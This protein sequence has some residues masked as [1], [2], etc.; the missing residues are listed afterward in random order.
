MADSQD[1][2]SNK[3]IN[4]Y[5]S[6][7]GRAPQ[8]HMDWE[9]WRKVGQPGTYQAPPGSPSTF[10][11]VHGGGG[12]PNYNADTNHYNMFAD[13][14][15]T[16]ESTVGSVG[17]WAAKK[18][19]GSR[20]GKMDKDK[21]GSTASSRNGSDMADD[22]GSMSAPPV[23]G[24]GRSQNASITSPATS[25]GMRR[26]RR[27]DF[28]GA[29]ASHGITMVQG[30]D[31]YGTINGNMGGHNF[32]SGDYD[33][34][35]QSKNTG[36]NQ[37]AFSGNNNA[38][39]VNINSGGPF[40]GG[41]TPPQ[42]QS[43]PPPV[44]P[45]GPGAPPTPPIVTDT[46]WEGPKR[47]APTKMQPPGTGQP[48]AL[49]GKERPML[50]TGQG[51]STY[52]NT[53][54]VPG[55]QET[56]DIAR[57]S[58]ITELATGGATEGE[59][60][61]AGTALNNRGTQSNVNPATQRGAGDQTPPMLAGYENMKETAPQQ[62]TR[63]GDNG[64][65]IPASAPNG[66]GMPQQF[67]RMQGAVPAQY[68]TPSRTYDQSNTQ[69]RQ[70][71]PSPF[72]GT[73]ETGP[74]MPAQYGAMQG[75]LRANPQNYATRVATAKPTQNQIAWPAGSQPAANNAPEAPAK[76]AGGRKAA[77]PKASAKTTEGPK[78]VAA[79]KAAVPKATAKTKEKK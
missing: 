55:A 45:S 3:D 77:A 33:N 58:K 44:G 21:S 19:K 14:N 6:Q 7:Q 13:L 10:R 39:P 69:I 54:G 15:K 36:G 35:F 61:A 4:R 24:G 18:Y 49:P 11:G 78:S 31:N 22:D 71:N 42:G 1:F 50:P 2:N 56:K 70:N 74:G 32:G 67:G 20:D 63:F 41:P 51:P 29:L 72:H 28:S 47:P 46:D 17:M 62:N 68:Q 66:G 79:K 27:G 9:T 30:N 37:T 43:G 34:S 40:G 64:M 48:P 60:D 65:G 73:G 8:S 5:L 52:G 12:G 75:A 26:G 23:A 25:R 57:E 76:K 59:R 38:G 53:E 16:I